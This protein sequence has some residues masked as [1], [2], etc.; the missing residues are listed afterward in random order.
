[1]VLH[2]SVAT[3]REHRTLA[4]PVD[5]RKTRQLPLGHQ[6]VVR[7]GQPGEVVVVSQQ[8]FIN[9]ALVATTVVQNRVRPPV[10]EIVAEGTALPP[11]APATYMS[12]ITVLTTGYWPNPAWSSG[13]TATGLRARYGIVAVDPRVI[14]MGTRLYIPGY[15]YGLAADVGSAVK[16]DHIDLCFDGPAQASNWGLRTETV[17]IVSEP[18]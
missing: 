5:V 6:E 4:F 12:A 18:N 3:V 15:G 14:P 11:G 9:G 17:Y 10:P 8:H 1:M 13:Y 2:A 7:A 16:G